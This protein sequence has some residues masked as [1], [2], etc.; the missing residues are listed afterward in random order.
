[1]K[2]CVLPIGSITRRTC[3]LS[4]IPVCTI[5]T[6]TQGIRSGGYWLKIFQNIGKLLPLRYWRSISTADRDF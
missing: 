5:I 3:V 1:M 2:I 4:I 6:I